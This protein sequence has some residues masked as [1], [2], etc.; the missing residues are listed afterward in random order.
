MNLPGIPSVPHRCELICLFGKSMESHSPAP[1]YMSFL[2]PWFLHCSVCCCEA[3][4]KKT[5]KQGMTS[6]LFPWGYF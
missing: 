1:H 3:A 5:N 4:L 2:T 6:G